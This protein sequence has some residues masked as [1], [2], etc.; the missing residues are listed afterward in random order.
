MRIVQAMSET[1]RTNLR[2]Q[3]HKVAAVMARNQG[4]PITRDEVTLK[5]A[6]QL[7]GTQAMRIYLE[8]R[9]MLEGIVNV[10][11]L[12]LQRGA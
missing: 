8:K 2:G 12:R 4:L 11:R 1:A 9:A 5:E 6:A 10:M 7:I 3:M